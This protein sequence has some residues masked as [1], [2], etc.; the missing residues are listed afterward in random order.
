MEPRDTKSVRVLRGENVLSRKYLREHIDAVLSLRFFMVSI[1]SCGSFI[2]VNVLRPYDIYIL[3]L[4]SVN[5]SMMP[6]SH[7]QS[8]GNSYTRIN[9]LNAS[10]RL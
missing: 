8:K 6:M 7:G 4:W 3:I 1:F 10:L 5:I 2:L 9:V